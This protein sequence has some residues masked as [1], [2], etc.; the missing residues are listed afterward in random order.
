M[1]IAPHITCMSSLLLAEAPS[2][3]SHGGQTQV[4]VRRRPPVGASGA[5]ANVLSCGPNFSFRVDG[6]GEEAKPQNILEEIVW[7]KDV[8]IGQRKEK[9]PFQT[10]VSAVKGAEPARDFVAALRARATET[11]APALIAEVKK[12]SPSRGVIR[13]DFNPVEIAKEYEEGGAACIS[14]LTDS[15][16][17]Q[18]DFEY[19]KEIRE[20]GVQCP[21]LCKDFIVEP[22]QIFLAR[23][24]GADCILL[25]AAV[26][27]DYDLKYL[28]KVANALG[29]AALVEVHTAEEA[30]RVLVLEGVTL[31]GIN[32]RDLGTFKVDIYNTAELLA[33][34]RGELVREKNILVV[35]E[36]GLFTPDDIAVVQRA[37]VGAVL[38]GESL[39]REDNPAKAIASLFG[40][41]I[42]RK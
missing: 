40:K 20:S 5:N 37:G 32:N 21:L 11:D 27:S 26:L 29:M 35:G 22:Y 30:D 36:S 31:M 42:S 4:T 17:F 25:I 41:D 14:V 1:L 33:G 39:V 15:K 13:E 9:V 7:W 18:G 16:Y 2:S 24:K 23:V 8:E 34:Q 3:S 6:L 19:L 28:L 10:L 38:V 12:A